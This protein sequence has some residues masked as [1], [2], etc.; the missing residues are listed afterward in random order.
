MR[1]WASYAGEGEAKEDF[2][3][4]HFVVGTPSVKNMF[5]EAGG[6]GSM[7]FDM[8]GRS[9]GLMF[10]G[11][12]H[13]FVSYFTPASALYDEILGV[14][15]AVDIGLPRARMQQ[16]CSRCSEYARGQ[17]LPF[18]L[19]LLPPISQPRVQTDA[20]TTQFSTVPPTTRNDLSTRSR[21]NWLQPGVAK[22]SAFVTEH[23]DQLNTP[24]A[25]HSRIDISALIAAL[26]LAELT[27]GKGSGWQ[28]PTRVAEDPAAVITKK[29]R[30]KIES[31]F[32][33]MS[34]E[35]TAGGDIMPQVVAGDL[36]KVAIGGIE[37][38]L[39]G[40][41]LLPPPPPYVSPYFPSSSP[42]QAGSDFLSTQN[43]GI[44]INGTQ[45]S[46]IGTVSTPFIVGT[47]STGPLEFYHSNVHAPS[48]PL[49][50]VVQTEVKP[51][52]G[53]QPKRPLDH[54]SEI[55][56][57][58]ERQQRKRPRLTAREFTPISPL[59]LPLPLLASDQ[60]DRPKRSLEDDSELLAA[61]SPQ[62]RK[63]HKLMSRDSSP[64]IRPAHPL[65]LPLLFSLSVPASASVK[66]LPY[67]SPPRPESSFSPET[68]GAKNPAA[69]QQHT[70]TDSPT[71]GKDRHQRQGLDTSDSDVDW[72]YYNPAELMAAS[73]NF[74]PDAGPDLD[75]A[76]PLDDD[77][78]QQQLLL[79]R[80]EGPEEQQLLPV[81]QSQTP[82]HLPLPP[83][84]FV[85]SE[86]I[87]LYAYSPL[88]Q[89][90]DSI[91]LDYI[92][93]SDLPLPDSLA[94][95]QA[96]SIQHSWQ[97]T[98]EEVGLEPEERVLYLDVDE[99][100]PGWMESLG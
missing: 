42:M 74:F 29:V 87:F 57:T 76:L 98:E 82:L 35:R 95:A 70:H 83:A 88:P 52:A 97:L 44:Q 69:R 45:S 89:R 80:S 50:Q 63:R 91:P 19:Q 67:P 24:A 5:S 53:N 15:G 85:G 51:P 93:T 22:F 8:G 25:K 54:D 94:L 71:P 41:L 36:S 60:G 10:G 1:F 39:S 26:G 17:T 16:I 65:P 58:L 2:T 73:I 75:L 48:H 12:S 49:P 77:E 28:M 3:T 84:P 7:V 61:L 21:F 92:S 34:R 32:Q 55:E 56:A 9:V 30:R 81:L 78:P 46:S 33:T 96:Q 79:P 27:D 4:D 66:T 18:A 43:R 40:H 20:S 23:W 100:G 86:S 90:L 14:T 37:E 11:N 68:S 38:D 64:E 59:A 6:S 31:V 13:S 62:Q 72:F 47:P 99:F